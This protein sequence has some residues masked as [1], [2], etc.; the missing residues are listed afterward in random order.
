MARS[1]FLADWPLRHHAGSHSFV[2]RAK[3]IPSATAQE[4][5]QLLAKPRQASMAAT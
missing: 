4:L 1:K 5:D 2:L 3:Y